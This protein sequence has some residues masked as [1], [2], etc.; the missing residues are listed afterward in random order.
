MTSFNHFQ[1]GVSR[2]MEMTKETVIKTTGT[3]KNLVQRTNT[4]DEFLTQADTQLVSEALEFL[5]DNKAFELDM[6]T[7]EV[8]NVI[9]VSALCR[10]I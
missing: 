1:V 2:D 3:L 5:A 6:D 8:E 10:L 9:E 4:T 7:D